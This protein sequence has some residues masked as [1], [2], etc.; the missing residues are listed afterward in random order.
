MQSNKTI[1]QQFLT[2]LGKGDAATM[3]T[4]IAPD[5]KAV[6]TGT[7]VLSCTRN[8]DEILGALMMLSQVTQNGIAFT[9]LSMTAEDDRVS[10][11][12]EGASTLVNGVPYNNQYHF[13]FYIRDGRVYL[14]KEYID[15]KLA[16]ATLG[17]LAAQQAA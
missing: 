10:V 16:D 13:L 15:T 8:H 2:A 6:C 7:S 17:A 9:V 4:L 1:A 3:A 5:V 14:L 12:A 11:E